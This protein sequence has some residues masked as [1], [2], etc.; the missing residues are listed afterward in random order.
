L[1]LPFAFLLLFFPLL[2][3]SAS[4]AV[5]KVFSLPFP[6]CLEL[7]VFFFLLWLHPNNL[8]YC[9]FFPARFVFGRVALSF[10]SGFLFPA[11]S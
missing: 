3:T 10:S 5:V 4:F 9:P 11:H 6:D 7:D 2:E 8:L 1:G